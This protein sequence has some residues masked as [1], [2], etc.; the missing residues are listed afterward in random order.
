MSDR[1]EK[2]RRVA[3]FA[4]SVVVAGGSWL[5]GIATCLARINSCTWLQRS[6]PVAFLAAA[7]AVLAGFFLLHRLP[8]FSS[9]AASRRTRTLLGLLV[10]PWLV[11]F[12]FVGPDLFGAVGRG[13]QKRTLTDM[14]TLAKALT[15]YH[16]TTGGYPD[17]ASIE[18]LVEAIAGTSPLPRRDGWGNLYLVDSSRDS[19]TIVSCG[20]CGIADGRDRR[21]FTD[22]TTRDAAADI[23]MTGG[24]FVQ[25]P[26]G[27]QAR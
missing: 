12:A 20:K 9:G 23:I 22:G 24:V 14:R 8:T 26:E 6:A 19:Y 10:G 7:T 13:R 5:A 1:R 4:L 17:A 18:T 15:R 25:F 3:W 27:T 16:E 11:G 21:A 2:L